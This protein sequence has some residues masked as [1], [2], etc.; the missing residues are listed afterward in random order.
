MNVMRCNETHVDAIDENSNHIN[1]ESKIEANYDSAE[2]TDETSDQL[3]KETLLR[4]STRERMPNSRYNNDYFIPYCIYV[5]YSDV[6]SPNSFEE[7]CQSN[8]AHESNKAMKCEIDS[9]ERNKT[10]ILMNKPEDKKSIDVKWVYKKTP[11]NF[12][13]AR[14]VVKGFQRTEHIENTY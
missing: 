5:N 10:W 14:L 13:K 3:I 6:N 1:N 8:E 11:E 4:R 9:M 7:A 12:Y 2:S